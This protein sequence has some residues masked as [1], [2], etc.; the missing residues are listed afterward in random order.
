VELR[1][2]RYFVAVADE[3][4]FGRAARRLF[5]SQP[6]LSQQIRGLEGELGLRLL[7]RNRRV[8]GR[9]VCPHGTGS[10]H[11]GPAHLADT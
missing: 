6:V 3:L 4:H 8:G 9:R 11:A 10:R 7:E 5:I 1:N 2:L